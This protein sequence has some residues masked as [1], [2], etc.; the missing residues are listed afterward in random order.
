MKDVRGYKISFCS[1]KILKDLNKYLF[2]FKDESLIFAIS[3]FLIS[4]PFFTWNNRISDIATIVSFLLLIKN[5]TIKRSNISFF[6]V[7]FF[8]FT[9][10]AIRSESVF[11]KFI[12]IIGTSLLFISS[13][14]FLLKSYNNYRFIYSITIVPSIITFFLVSYGSFDL[15]FNI[16]DPINNLKEYTYRQYP[17]LLVPTNK[18]SEII[19]PRFHGYYDEPGVVGTISG[20]LLLSDRYNLK[21][22]VNI[23]I[24]ISGIMSFSLAFY[25]ITII[26]Y[27]RFFLYSKIK[28]KLILTT[29]TLILIPVLLNDVTI[30]KYIISR[31]DFSH[32]QNLLNLRTNES[33]NL[34]FDNFLKTPNV[35][36]G[37][38]GKVSQEVFNVG[39]SS[40]KDIIV[41]YGII[42]SFMFSL[43]VIFY[44][45]KKIKDYKRTFFYLLIFI[46]IIYQR[47]Y[48]TSFFYMF[49][50]FAP[51]DHLKKIANITLIEKNR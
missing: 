32:G 6:I 20:V 31:F 4:S 12:L 35:F 40:Y 10:V 49:L 16:I 14:N 42:F 8:L 25:V 39:G 50:L 38:G 26:Y 27:L 5:I 33:F 22:N 46:L 24:F 43:L 29:V 11:F 34:W 23:P 19:I 30:N 44:S 36:F 2:F 13:E 7:F 47:P 17:F 9:Y 3:I 37:L 15:N 18:I 41:N 28:W 1:N 48:I 45:L 51:I 21:K